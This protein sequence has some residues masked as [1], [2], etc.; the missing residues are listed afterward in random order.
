MASIVNKEK[1]NKKI[2][3]IHYGA[4]S[5]V[6]NNV[7]VDD[8]G[9]ITTSTNVHT[10]NEIEGDYHKMIDMWHMMFDGENKQ[11][12][13]FD[14]IYCLIMAL[15]SNHTIFILGNDKEIPKRLSYL[16]EK[17]MVE[18]SLL[19]MKS[20]SYKV[21]GKSGVAI[22]EKEF[23]LNGFDKGHKRELNSLKALLLDELKKGVLD[24]NSI[25]ALLGKIYLRAVMYNE[26]I[27]MELEELIKNNLIIK[28][29]SKP[30]TLDETLNSEFMVHK[31]N[32]RDLK[33]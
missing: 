20:S 9:F 12:S 18:A 6:L 27:D 4:Y 23:S 14:K 25:I 16:N 11:I 2:N 1:E 19:F 7:K 30:P 13:I 3:I 29:S 8:Y 17:L 24:Y 28:I 26:E 10:M 33:R 22:A 15:K 21:N 31:K 5:K 32:F